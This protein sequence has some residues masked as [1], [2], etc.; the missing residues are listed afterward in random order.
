[1]KFIKKLLIVVGLL[2]AGGLIA[3]IAPDVALGV[4]FV[5]LALFS[6]S[7]IKPI[8]K[9]G[10]DSRSY[11]FVLLIFVALPILS[12]GSAEKYNDGIKEL[13]LLKEAD[14]A[15]YLA[16]LKR[17]SPTRWLAELEDLDAEAYAAEMDRRREEEEL[18]ERRD[19]LAFQAAMEVKREEEC[20]EKNAS[21]AYVMS[22]E[23]V[24]RQ[25]RAPSTAKFPFWP[26]D[27]RSQALGECR[28]LVNSFVDAQNGFGAMLRSYY[29]VTL[30]YDPSDET[31]RAEEVVIQ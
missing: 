15:S 11:A 7:L 27:Y 20:G 5:L 3:A 24:K 19:F 16:E 26:D 9:I 23:F 13:E 1:M 25:L 2:L 6:V 17:L 18:Q 8:S 4:G 28:Y 21:T 30:I 10:L 12:M 22:Q 14:P 29:R 31:W